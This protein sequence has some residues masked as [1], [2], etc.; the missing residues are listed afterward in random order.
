[1]LMV[2]TSAPSS[3]AEPGVHAVWGSIRHLP[4]DDVHSDRVSA[5]GSLG[6]LMIQLSL[7]LDISACK[8]M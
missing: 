7:A 2:S 6:K 8:L 5:V 3:A 4:E 1:M